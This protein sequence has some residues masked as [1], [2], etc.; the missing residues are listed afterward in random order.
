MKINEIIRTRRTA[1]GLTQE[2][3]AQLLGVSA[4]AV[5]KWEK[6]LN[7]PDITLLP[8]L[9][10]ILGV[11]LNT[12][13]SFQEDLTPEEIGRFSEQVTMVAQEQS[14]AA[15]FQLAREKMQEFPSC[16]LLT[17]TMA[18]LL[19]GILNLFPPKKEEAEPFHQEV[20]QLY[21][22]AANSHDPQISQWACALLAGRYIAQGQL[23][24]A[25]PLLKQLPQSHK[26]KQLL[27]ASLAGEGRGYR[28]CMDAAGAGAVD[29]G[30]RRSGGAEPPDG[31]GRR[32]K[33]PGSGRSL[34]RRFPRYCGGSP[35]SCRFPSFS[36]FPA[37]PSAKGWPPCPCFAG[38]NLPEHT[39]PCS[40]CRL[41]PLLS[42]AGKGRSRQ[43][44]ADDA[45]HDGKGSGRR[46]GMCFSPGFTPVCPLDEKMAEKRISGIQPITKR[47]APGSGLQP[48]EKPLSH[49]RPFRSIPH[50]SAKTGDLCVGFCTSQGTSVRQRRACRPLQKLE[51]VAKPLFRHAQAPPSE[52]GPLLYYSIS[53]IS[54]TSWAK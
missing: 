43:G 29:P 2:A 3:L 4:P 52:S 32:R 28:R 1:Q 25:R 51:K 7:Y 19:E 23:E 30:K 22:R 15:A 10:R 24:Q 18:P 11:D 48:V 46:S 35:P 50:Q 5:N 53:S 40:L 37:G 42:L 31:S 54:S 27:Q 49:E 12:L 33:G 34:C 6:G 17:Y 36:S 45:A 20:L 26:N 8:A 13:L 39:P 16:D 14:C 9:A 21:E 38:G 41:P 47:P 44:P